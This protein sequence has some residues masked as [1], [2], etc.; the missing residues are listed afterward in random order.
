MNVQVTDLLGLKSL[1]KPLENSISNLISALG[2]GIGYWSEP[3]MIRMRAKSE[4][5]ATE[6]TAIAD[7]R[8]KVIEAIGGSI[9]EKVG[10]EDV[11]K[12][13][14][15]EGL[16][17]RAL[18]RLSDES[19]RFQQNRESIAA[20]S[21]A[22]FRKIAE[23]S[24]PG[25]EKIDDDW[26]SMFW[27]T[28]ESCSD[29]T[30]QRLFSRI[31]AGEAYQP[32][33]FGPRTVQTV[34]VMTRE[35][36]EAF[37]KACSLAFHSPE[38]GTHILEATVEYHVPEIDE[39]MIDPE[40]INDL[41]SLGI[42]ARGTNFSF[43]GDDAGSHIWVGDLECVIQVKDGDKVGDTGNALAAAPFSPLGNELRRVATFGH[44]ERY[45]GGLNDVLDRFGVRLDPVASK[46]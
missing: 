33:S 1:A 15:S 13:P 35:S 26:I 45:F 24:D 46:E 31:L 9:A 12:E 6:L 19:I 8:A 20:H 2:K 32:G 4:A 39:Q 43:E 41:E 23:S 11:L 3:L 22:E 36:A 14:T 40:Q 37:R 25:D 18:L 16:A 30:M 42:L 7:A 34:S 17:Y 21:L 29:E 44:D 27:R 38:L 5:K 28:V 10:L